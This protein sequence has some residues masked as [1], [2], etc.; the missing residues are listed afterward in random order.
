MQN[1]L[2]ERRLVARQTLT[3]AK[4]IEKG[5]AVFQKKWRQDVRCL[6]DLHFAVT[7]AVAPP[8]P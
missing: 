4:R 7:S 6:S 8:D 3:T 1:V 2:H 5:I